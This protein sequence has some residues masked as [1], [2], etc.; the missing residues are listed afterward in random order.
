MLDATSRKFHA[1]TTLS[2]LPPSND[3]SVLDDVTFEPFL[4][5]HINTVELVPVF[6]SNC[7]ENWMLYTP[8]VDTVNLPPLD[9]VIPDADNWVSALIVCTVPATPTGWLF[10]DMYDP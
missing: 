1:A 8:V 7:A 4:Y 9:I 5:N 6:F 3:T 10:D 2:P